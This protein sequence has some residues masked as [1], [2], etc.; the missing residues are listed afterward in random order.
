MVSNPSPEQLAEFELRH[1]F[2]FGTLP[3]INQFNCCPLDP[4]HDLGEGVIP[5]VLKF[6]FGYWADN[7]D[8]T[9]DSE[10]I[11]TKMNKFSFYEGHPV[12]NTWTKQ[13]KDKVTNRVIKYL[14]LFSFHAKGIQVSV[15]IFVK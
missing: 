5:T 10:T 4:M 3:G 12:V 11:V 9:L 15:H 8:D 6:I 7:R 13:V 1:E 14:H 2:I